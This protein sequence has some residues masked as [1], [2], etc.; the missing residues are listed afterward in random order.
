MNVGRILTLSVVRVGKEG[1][2]NRG[3]EKIKYN[4]VNIVT[5]WPRS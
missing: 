3:L 2:K 1:K 5:Q 4:N